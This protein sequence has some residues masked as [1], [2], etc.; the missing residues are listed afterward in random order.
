MANMMCVATAFLTTHVL[1]NKGTLEAVQACWEK[2]LLTRP[3]PQHGVWLAWC[4]A[5]WRPKQI[6]G[7]LQKILKEMT[8]FSVFSLG[9][10]SL[11]QPGLA[12]WPNFIST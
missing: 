2:G 12:G 4:D 6:V 1:P 10:F 7:K 8:F 5:N 9:L 11:A 3:P